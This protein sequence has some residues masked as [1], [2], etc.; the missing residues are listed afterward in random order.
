MLALVLNVI[1]NVVVLNEGGASMACVRRMI[2]EV[3][4]KRALKERVRAADAVVHGAAGDEAEQRLVL[5]R[6][7][8]GL[9]VV[10]DESGCV[11]HQHG[12]PT[13][14]C[15]RHNVKFRNVKC[16]GVVVIRS[17]PP[18]SSSPS[19]LRRRSR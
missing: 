5:V 6:R 12:P 2:E 14:R 3:F 11:R 16:P 4:S 10:G 17:S 7:E 18:A 1:R 13:S 15:V 19:M 9:D 8:V